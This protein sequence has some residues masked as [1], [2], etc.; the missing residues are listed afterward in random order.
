M[1]SASEYRRGVSLLETLIALAIIAMVMAVVTTSLRPPS[2]SM[3]LEQRVVAVLSESNALHLRAIRSGQDQPHQTDHSCSDGEDAIWFFADGTMLG[4]DLCLE[5][6]GLSARL[7]A[8][9]LTGT[10]QRE[11]VR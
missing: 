11:P 10:Y 1:T 6:S 7:I 8:D 3:L 2:P 9:P 4:P 5:E